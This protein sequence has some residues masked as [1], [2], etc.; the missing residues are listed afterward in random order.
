MSVLTGPTPLPPILANAP[1]AAA[2]GTPLVLNI[3]AARALGALNNPLVETLQ[4]AAGP[5]NIIAGTVAESASDGTVSVT[6]PNG[7]TITLRQLPELPLDPGSAIVLRLLPN[8][9]APQAVL[10]AV[11]GRPVAARGAAISAAATLGNPTPAPAAIATRAGA[12]LP[13]PGAISVAASFIATISLQDEAAIE[14]ALNDDPLTLGTSAAAAGSEDSLV[15]T[16]VATLIRP[17]PAKLGQIPVPVGTRYLVTLRDVGGADSSGN[18][19]GADSS[20]NLGSADSSAPAT[21]EPL[22]SSTLSKAPGT[23][24]PVSTAVTVLLALQAAGGSAEATPEELEPPPETAESE[25]AASTAPPPDADGAMAPASSADEAPAPPPLAEQ[26]PPA[27]PSAPAGKPALAPS[28]L[29]PA[30]DTTFQPQLSTLAGRVVV[31]R[32]LAETAVQT[33]IG[34]LALPLSEPLPL[35]VAVQLRISA[36]A[37]P[38][39]PGRLAKAEGSASAPG[40]PPLDEMPTTLV[41]ELT[42]AVAA[43]GPATVADLHAVLTLQPGDGLAAAI[44][45]FLS[46]IRPTAGGARAADLPGRKALLDI[47]RT[48]LAARLDRAAGE[49]GTARPPDAPDGWTV[50]T[51]PFLGMASVRPV[52]LYR[53]RHQDKD[54]DGRP[55]GKPSDR[56]V[57]EVELKRMGPLQFDG[58]VRDR[59]FDL[60]VRSRDAFAPVLQTVV[61]QA[62]RDGLLVSG[63][64]GEI[65]FGRTGKFPMVPD[66]HSAAHLDLGA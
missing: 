62:F 55:R 58:L 20:G 50:T 39:L 17:A 26:S 47:G 36:V 53:K 22:P 4:T 7:A 65:G 29:P 60:V 34:T 10:L 38:L 5:G 66:P 46:G 13:T 49:I 24:A 1:A 42:Q 9:A 44:F 32:Q 33:A 59:R 45:T 56:F 61:E 15:E 18:L 31:P 6:T 37:P 25:A 40:A 23:Q 57:L 12:A 3:L 8:T 43:S 19:G 35:G 54:A 2:E 11:D 51:L 48:D 16:V 30:D 63:W 64:S 21:A 28:P 52:R 27:T 14:A 41:E